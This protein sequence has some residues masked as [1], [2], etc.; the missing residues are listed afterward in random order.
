MSRG[1]GKTEKAALKACCQCFFAKDIGKQYGYPG[2]ARFVHPESKA[3]TRG[4]SIG[5]KQ[6]RMT[7]SDEKMIDLKE[8]HFYFKKKFGTPDELSQAII[9]YGM[10]EQ[11]QSYE[12]ARETA[13]ASYGLMGQIMGQK[14]EFR[15]SP[16]QEAS[17]QRAVASLRKKGYLVDANFGYAP[18]RFVKI[19]EKK[20][21]PVRPR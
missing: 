11:N 10:K 9:D 15:I 2:G 3:Y 6:N 12:Q 14:T 7:I 20:I 8:V 17:Y 5:Q 13:E 18:N 19:N 21:K 16:A 4:I 1:L